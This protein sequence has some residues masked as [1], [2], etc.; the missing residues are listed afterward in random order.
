MRGTTLK[1]TLV[2]ALIAAPTA[3]AAQLPF[4][5][6]EE[7]RY[8]ASIPRLGG[9]GSGTMRV[10]GF[11][12]VRGHDA[13]MVEFAFNGRVGP[14]A[15]SDLTRSWF[16]PSGMAG[17]RF[18]KHERTPL[19][20]TRRQ[21]ELFPE[22][23]RWEGRGESGGRMTTSAPLDELSFLYFLRTL[24][25]QPGSSFVVSRHFEVD[26]NPISVRVL[27]RETIRVPAGEFRT[28]VVEMVVRD[29]R[30]FRGDGRIRLHLSDDARRLLVRMETSMPLAGPT[31]LSLES[32]VSGRQAIAAG[33]GD[34]PLTGGGQILTAQAEKLRQ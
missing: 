7:L 16:V 3:G 25:L 33:V 34:S 20:S 27:G 31:V 8:S 11:E 23:R 30:A 4:A 21:I 26:R 24:P 17:L 10:V 2:T 14:G 22:Q 5:I 13:V 32:W 19:S 29:P 18:E 28:V 6:G 12:R 9:S 15:I 1:L